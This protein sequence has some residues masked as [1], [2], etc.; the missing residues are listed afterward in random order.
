VVFSSLC[1]RLTSR[2]LDLAALF[3]IFILIGITLVYSA[4]GHG[5]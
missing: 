4:D 3:R 1:A 5:N 2:E